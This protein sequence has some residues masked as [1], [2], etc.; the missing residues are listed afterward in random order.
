MLRVVGCNLPIYKIRVSQYFGGILQMS[1]LPG[2]RTL[3]TTRVSRVQRD[4]TELVLWTTGLKCV[5]PATVPSQLLEDFRPHQTPA[6][7]VSVTQD[8]YVYIATEEYQNALHI[9][10]TFFSLWAWT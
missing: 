1:V 3:E 4:S 7:L 8:L 9:V 6:T 10:I 5:P 2:M